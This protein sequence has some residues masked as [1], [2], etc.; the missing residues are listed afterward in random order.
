MSNF[1]D[2]M[3]VMSTPSAN[4]GVMPTP[5]PPMGPPCYPDNYTGFTVEQQNEFTERLNKQGLLLDKIEGIE[6]PRPYAL[7]WRPVT[8]ARELQPGY[9]SRTDLVYLL[10]RFPPPPWGPI[11]EELRYKWQRP[12]EAAYWACQQA[13]LHEQ[14]LAA[15]WQQ[16][17]YAHPQQDEM[18]GQS[19]QMHAQ[20]WEA[21][22]TEETLAAAHRAA[23]KRRRNDMAMERGDSGVDVLGRNNESRL[24]ETVAPSP[25]ID[26]R[27]LDM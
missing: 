13:Q 18:G 2:N 24:E 8:R 26:S 7:L 9:D 4:M 20:Y 17:P 23:E 22:N 1:G 16:I 27:L 10:S 15:G 3:A 11:F 14:Q 25:N 12:D 19:A 6:V 21:R 5:T